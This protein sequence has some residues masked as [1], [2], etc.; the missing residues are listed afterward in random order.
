MKDVVYVVLGAE[1][2]RR[3]TKRWPTLARD[4]IGVKVTITAP[5]NAFRSPVLAVALDVQDTH[6][7]QPIVTIEPEEA[8]E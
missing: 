7:I 4:E 2:A 6:V 8:P 3:M 5:D 1:G